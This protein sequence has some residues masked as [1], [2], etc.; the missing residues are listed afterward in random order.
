MILRGRMLQGRGKKPG[1]WL[2]KGVLKY[3]QHTNRRA[4]ISV[5]RATRIEVHIWAVR[6]T[7]KK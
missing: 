5:S 7:Q 4:G 6:R 2:E 3:L 1:H